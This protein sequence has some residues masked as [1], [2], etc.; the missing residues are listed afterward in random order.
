MTT[1]YFMIPTWSSFA[2][3][4]GFKDKEQNLGIATVW[5]CFQ[6]E[7]DEHKTIELSFYKDQ[8][9]RFCPT[10]ASGMAS[11]AVF[12]QQSAARGETSSSNCGG[13]HGWLLLVLLV[14]FNAAFIL[15]SYRTPISA[16]SQDNIYE[17]QPP[18]V[19]RK[20]TEIFQAH[21]Q[22]SHGMMQPLGKEDTAMYR[23]YIRNRYLWRKPWGRQS[24]SVLSVKR[25]SLDLEMYLCGWEHRLLFQ[26]LNLVPSMPIERLITFSNSNYKGS[27]T[28]F[29]ILRDLYS[30]V[31][32]HTIKNNT[33]SKIFK[34]WTPKSFAP[35]AFH[36][37]VPCKLQITGNKEM[38]A[39]VGVLLLM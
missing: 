30:N 33:K 34:K 27:N 29:W 14:F 26:G 9:Q 32:V 22:V 37:F 1:P 5:R 21:I 39:S 25:N 17:V 13:P 18:R 11:Q 15:I 10:W 38:V 6:W 28:A 31:C 20:S 24:C 19:D 16:F 3:P 7:L 23:E 36:A 8:K 2:K 4:S 35:E 12:I